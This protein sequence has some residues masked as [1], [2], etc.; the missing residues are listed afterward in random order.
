M[1]QSELVLP[2]IVVPPPL[3]HRLAYP[4][5]YLHTGVTVTVQMASNKTR[6]WI[7]SAASAFHLERQLHKYVGLLVSSCSKGSGQA[8][9]GTTH[10]Q[11]CS[12]TRSVRK[13][14]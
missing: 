5:L 11:L 12:K 6:S 1:P 13:A 3:L 9:D 8:C 2:S 4:Y 10:R 7:H 14:E